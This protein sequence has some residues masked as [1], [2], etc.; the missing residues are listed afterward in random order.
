MTLLEAALRFLQAGKPVFPVDCET[1]RPLAE[2]KA[3]QQRLP[4]DQQIKAWWTH[5]PRANIGMATGGLSGVVVVDCDSEEATN[6]FI[7]NYPEAKVTLQVQTG[8]GQHFLFQFEEG[9]RNDAGRVLGPGTDIRGDGGFVI[10][11]PS[12]HANGTVYKWLNKNK[13]SHLP[14]TLRTRLLDKSEERKMPAPAVNGRIPDHQRNVTLT[15]FA[16]SMHRRGMS[17][18]SILVAL[19]EENRNRCDPPLD[20]DEVVRIANSVAKYQPEQRAAVGKETKS[21]RSPVVVRL[22]DVQREEVSWLWQDR[23]PIGKLTLFDGDPGVGK[24]WLTL[25]VTTAVTSGVPLPQDMAR[26]PG[27]VMLLTAEDGLGDTVRPRLEDMGANLDL[28]NALKGMRDE[29]GQERSLT[30]ADIDVLEATLKEHGPSLVVVDPV[31]A[32]VAGRDTWKASEVRGLLAPL[33]A[34]AEKYRCAVIGVR[35]LTKQSMKAIYRGQGSIDF[36]AACRSAFLVAENPDN[37]D[38]RVICHLKYNLAPKTPS[39]TFTVKEGRFLWGGESSLTA[40]QVLATPAGTEDKSEQDEAKEFLRDLLSE[41]PLPSSE[42]KKQ[43][44]EAGIAERTLWRAKTALGVKAVKGGFQ[45][46]WNWSLPPEACQKDSKAANSEGLADLA[47]F[48]NLGSLRDS[49]EGWEEV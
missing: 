47:H 34:L 19:L 33:A 40:E 31:V 25:A 11:P 6:R 14:E 42:V 45:E 24:S 18:A 12:V 15:S 37:P 13:P 39:L 36:L 3:F 20:E 2:W 49:E 21:E 27:K 22:S 38:Q 29:K 35:H 44:K 4:T 48:G 7:E 8:R 17:E 23:I 28:V 5:W 46:G 30:L 26:E 41:G 43:A 32:Y 10:I 16:G 1:K 9:I